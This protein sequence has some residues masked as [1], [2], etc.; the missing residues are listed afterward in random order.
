MFGNTQISVPT[1]SSRIK[2]VVNSSSLVTGMGTIS[3]VDLVTS[4]TAFKFTIR[5]RRGVFDKYS[6]DVGSFKGLGK[7]Q[8]V[9]SG[10]NYTVGDLI[11][12]D[13]YGVYGSGAKARVSE[14][15]ASG[16][17]INTEFEYDYYENFGTGIRNNY[18]YSSQTTIG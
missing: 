11:D 6:G 18:A 14:T 9:D 13:N 10:N 2:H 1:V 17:I 12:F 4:N 8:I 3:N 16:S 5:W 15:N 7:L